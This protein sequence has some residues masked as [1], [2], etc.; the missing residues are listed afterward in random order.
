M[1]ST[2]SNSATNR[3]TKENTSW[4]SLW[5]EEAQDEGSRQQQLIDS[6]SEWAILNAY[7]ELPAA[8]IKAGRSNWLIE[9]WD[10]PRLETVHEAADLFSQ[11][12]RA[13]FALSHWAIMHS[14][15]RIVVGDHTIDAGL[16]SWVAWCKDASLEELQQ[17]LEAVTE[18]EI[19]EN[20][21]HA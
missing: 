19:E 3:Y 21:T 17:A 15:P 6:L 7:P 1:I 14:H 12:W 4:P 8:G 2:V 20:T 13:Y 16:A 11:R 5:D 18:H 9:A 10:L